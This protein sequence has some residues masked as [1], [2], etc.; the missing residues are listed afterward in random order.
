MARTFAKHRRAARRTSMQHRTQGGLELHELLWHRQ[1][2][3]CW[4]C[5]ETL[6]LDHATVDHQCP[7]V[8]GGQ[9]TVDNCVVACRRCN[10]AKGRLSLDAYRRQCEGLRFWG[11]NR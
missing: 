3:R 7:V 8:D 5:G 4:Y 10:R 6:P 1:C 9:H 11:E 2:Q